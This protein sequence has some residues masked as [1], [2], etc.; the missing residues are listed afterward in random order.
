MV[1]VP[2][3]PT[4]SQSLRSRLA[5][6]Y[7]LGAL[8]DMWSH[9]A[10]W[11]RWVG[12]GRIVITAVAVVVTVIGGIWLIRTPDPDSVHEA[13]LAEARSATYEPVTPTEYTLIT[14]PTSPA[15]VEQ[16]HEDPGHTKRQ[17]I[18]HVVGAVLA[19][20]VYTLEIGARVID[21][22]RA[23]GGPTDQAQLD[24][25]NLAAPTSDGQRLVVPTLA[26]VRSG[27]YQ[28]PAVVRAPDSPTSSPTSDSPAGSSSGDS[29]ININTAGEEELTRLPGVGPAIAAA[30]VADRAQR[31]PFASV[32]ELIRVRGIG[33][34]KLNALRPQARV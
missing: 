6:G 18:V 25:M 10:A 4:P 12:V 19:P 29:R 32:E 34:A 8:A 9:L 30:I 3:R 2:P 14:V 15:A 1:V 28:A 33:P 23:A 7:A 31:G 11:L 16:D 17:V 26:E 21:A 27:A 24:A 22:V 20:G 5:G 13:A